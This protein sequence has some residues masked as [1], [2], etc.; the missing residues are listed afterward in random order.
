MDN[1]TISYGG[2]TAVVSDYMVNGKNIPAICNIEI[3]YNGNAALHTACDRHF[4]QQHIDRLVGVA[5]TICQAE[6]PGEAV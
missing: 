3:H 4:A 2:I 6:N 5:E 1:T